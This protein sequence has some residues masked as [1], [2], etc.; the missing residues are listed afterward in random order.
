MK[1]L[2]LLTL[3]VI[4]SINLS[5][6]SKSKAE[7]EAEGIALF[8]SAI[9]AIEAKDFATVPDLWESSSNS[10]T[11]AN[12]DD[13]NF[14]GF[15]NGFLY[16]Q[17]MIVASNSYTNK[18][19][20]KEMTNEFDKKGNYKVVMQVMGAALS[21]R[22]EIF[23]KKGGNY[24]EFIVTPSKGVVRRFSGEIVHRAQS[25]YRKRANEI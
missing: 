14:I 12:T 6:Q 15:E 17:G 23:L 24:A 3:L 13:Y 11:E 5:S 9:A 1:R 16:L 19:T 2:F 25:K 7:K 18:T 4:T 10:I 21:A 8:N 20:V 22:V